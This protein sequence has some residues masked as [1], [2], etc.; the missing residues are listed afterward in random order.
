MLLIFSVNTHGLFN[1]KIKK[2]LQLLINS[3]QKILDQSNR[4]IAKSKE[5]KPKT[6]WEDRDSEF[7]NRPIKSWLEKDDI[8]MYSTPNGRKSVVAKRFSRNLKK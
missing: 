5:H 2:L 8:E 4:R 3:F 6:I 7:Y 1:W